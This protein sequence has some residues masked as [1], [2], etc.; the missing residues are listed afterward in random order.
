[1]KKPKQYKRYSSEFKREA[2]RRASEEGI[3]DAAVYAELDI[4]TRQFRRWRE[5]NE[6]YV[7]CLQTTDIPSP[8]SGFRGSISAD[9]PQNP[10]SKV[11]RFALTPEQS[12]RTIL[13]II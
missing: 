9:S 7:G 8:S 11:S 4:S 13:T 12:G 3:M 6:I 10:I 5:N 1:M 2:I